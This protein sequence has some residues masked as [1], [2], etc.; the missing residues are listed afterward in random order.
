MSWSKI[1]AIALLLISVL[2]VWLTFEVWAAAFLG[3]LIALSLNG[4]AEWIRSKWRMPAWVSTVLTM[5]MVLT[6]L[7]GL[8]F[9]IGPPLVKQADEL[10]RKLPAA[11]DQSLDWLE[12]RQWGRNVVQKGESLSG[13][14]AENLNSKDKDEVNDGDTNRSTNPNQNPTT[15][16]SQQQPLATESAV[17]S[18]QTGL[19]SDASNHAAA[20]GQ[21]ESAH[22]QSDDD[23]D[24]EDDD[25]DDDEDSEGSDD[26]ESIFVPILKTVG[27]ML[28]RTAWIITLI[29]VSLVITLYVALNP[30]V[31]RRGF[32]WLIPAEHEA[33][34][35]LTMTHMCSALRWWML[36]RLASMVA[37]GLLTSLGMWLIGM[38]APLALGA[39]AG[40]LSFVPNVG[41]IVAALP[42]LLLAFPEG[43]WMV[44]FVLGVYVG[45]QIIESNLI[46]PMVDQFTVTIPPA[47]LIFI[48]LIMAVLVGAWGVLVATPVLVV[49]TVLAQQL[50]VREYLK[51][52]IKVIG[53]TEDETPDEQT[54]NQQATRSTPAPLTP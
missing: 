9:L 41:P 33:K 32:L 36:G 2:I 25:G 14:S 24:K 45:A 40:L 53:S 35:T 48:Q 19:M 21:V 10:G 44:L 42:G 51:R 4:P 20:G 39:L 43:A 47:V 22:A 29:L 16:A 52:P 12:D 8:G 1:S 15:D 6:V 28:M 11:M 38:P 46:S 34:A 23:N 37:V 5:L 3:L 13:M 49:V 18:S 54:D 31:Y 7:T 50:Y 26:V 30:E 17:D 27:S